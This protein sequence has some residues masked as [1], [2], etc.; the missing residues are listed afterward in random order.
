MAKSKQT[1]K[2]AYACAV[3]M[4]EWKY[5]KIKYIASNVSVPSTPTEIGVY[6]SSDR[7]TIV[8][9]NPLNVLDSARRRKQH[10]RRFQGQS[11]SRKQS[12]NMKQNQN[13][14][15]KRKRTPNPDRNRNRGPEPKRNP[16][17]HAEV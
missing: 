15:Q 9:H 12:Q 8:H 3:Q 14:N 4:G 6:A 7:A 11:Q 1:E 16:A 5:E 2:C 13:R 10:A 17:T